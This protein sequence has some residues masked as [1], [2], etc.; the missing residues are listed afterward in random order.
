MNSP[1]TGELCHPLSPNCGTQLQPQHFDSNRAEQ[2]M[3]HGKIRHFASLEPFAYLLCVGAMGSVGKR[4]DVFKPTARKDRYAQM[5][6]AGHHGLSQNDLPIL[7]VDTFKHLLS[8]PPSF[9]SL[10]KPRLCVQPRHWVVTFLGPQLGESC[11]ASPT[12]FVSVIP[13]TK[14]IVQSCFHPRFGG[15]WVKNRATPK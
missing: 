15:E 7:R 4:G 14:N 5:T 10:S 6:S 11:C 8:A 13:F 2:N 1:V 9:P 3:F 12:H